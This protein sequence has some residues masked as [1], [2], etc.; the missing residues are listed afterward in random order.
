MKVVSSVFGSVCVFFNFLLVQRWLKGVHV[1][2]FGSGLG[3]AEIRIRPK[4]K[5]MEMGYKNV[6]LLVSDFVTVLFLACTPIN[7]HDSFK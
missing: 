7:E 3:D 1:Y 4:F 6:F 5:Q 2:L